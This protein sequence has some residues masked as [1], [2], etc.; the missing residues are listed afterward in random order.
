M[1]RSKKGGF[2]LIYVIC[3]I[4]ILSA[5]TLSALVLLSTN[6]ISSAHIDRVNKAQ[7]AAETGIDKGISKLKT[8]IAQQNN[9]TK[10]LDFEKDPSKGHI[11]SDSDIESINKELES[12]APNVTIDN[13]DSHYDSVTG[14]NKKCIKITSTG[15]YQSV[16]KTIEAYIDEQNIS[17]IY[18]DRLF[19]N[20]LTSTDY[21]SSDKFTFNDSATG[22]APAGNNNFTVVKSAKENSDGKPEEKWDLIAYKEN[23]PK[24]TDLESIVSK[25]YD[26]I[27]DRIKNGDPNWGATKEEIEKSWIP[28]SQ[29]DRYMKMLEAAKGSADYNK[30]KNYNLDDYIKIVDKDGENDFEKMLQYSTFYKVIFINGDIKASNIKR[31]LVNYVIYCNG[32]IDFGSPS[33]ENKIRFWNC[34]IYASTITIGGVH[35]KISKSEDTNFTDSNK[36]IAYYDRTQGKVVFRSN[37]EDLNPQPNVEIIGVTSNESKKSIL[38]YIMNYDD[39]PEPY[40]RLEGYYNISNQHAEAVF[41]S[42]AVGQFSQPDMVAINDFLLK[43]INEYAYGLKFRIIDWK[44]K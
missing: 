12:N 9:W 32:D 33:E 17:N 7:L 37:G 28:T 24:T 27:E 31:P 3:V 41:P 44:E 6:R 23:N 2:A 21:D 25:M 22:G 10:Y 26:Y 15:K 35:Y 19:D 30:I 39:D 38:K 8:E 36:D 40:V 20:P 4:V 34:N 11:Y 42:T 14:T 29:N 5:L 18:F 1:H 43:N 16:T 13:V